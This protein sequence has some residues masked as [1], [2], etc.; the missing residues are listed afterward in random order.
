[1]RILL[2]HNYL[3]TRGGEDVMF[4]S[5]VKLLKE[6]KHEI[7]TYK[8]Q[9]INVERNKISQMKAALNMFSNQDVKKEL[10][11]IINSFRPQIAHIS[12]IFPLIT[13][14]I[15]PLLKSFNIPIVQSIHS[16]RLLCPKS[17]FYRNREVCTLCIDKK[18]AYPTIFYGCY[19]NS[20]LASFFFST[21]FYYHQMHDK[22]SLIDRFLFPA[23]FARNL[24]I[25]YLPIPKS[26]TIVIPNFIQEM[27]INTE[28][29]KEKNLFLFV[30]RLSE[31][32][33]I[34]NLLNI[35]TELPHIKLVIIGQG[36][37]E[38]KV[39]QY[40][41][42]KNIIIKGYVSKEEVYTHMQKAMFTII[43]SAPLYEFGPLA[44]IESYA[45]GTPVI[46]P[47]A[48]GFNERITDKKNGFFYS[49]G[50]QGSLKAKILECSQIRIEDTKYM[51]T[52]AF[53]EYQMKYSSD[54]YYQN[55]TRIYNQLINE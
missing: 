54:I 22:L 43:P 35:F 9:S 29:K 36:P 3:S 4:D 26:K 5:T 14:L 46:A 47:K 39:L 34:L 21:S 42:Y 55:I 27:K 6:R 53:T 49:V 41:K 37:L 51:D 20:R 48:G 33:G 45:C 16:H 10:C 40:S 1:M 38:K 8:K 11:T 12:N 23:T 28:I 25:K 19:H 24:H 18:F 2:V 7:Y 32:K 30:G 17:T 50:K 44:L 15:Y 52:E 31:E 13:P